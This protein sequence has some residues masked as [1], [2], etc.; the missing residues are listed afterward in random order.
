[1]D[2]HH[3]PETRGVYM[4]ECEHCGYKRACRLVMA[5]ARYLWKCVGDCIEVAS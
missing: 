5:G 4:T 2:P 1:M 3:D